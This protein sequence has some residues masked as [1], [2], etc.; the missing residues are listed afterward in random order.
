MAG[1]GQTCMIHSSK[2]DIL[3]GRQVAKQEWL[4][5]PQFPPKVEMLEIHFLGK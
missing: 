4:D 1:F 3:R 5:Q 2:D